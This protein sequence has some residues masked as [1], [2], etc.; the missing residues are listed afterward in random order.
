MYC[1]ISRSVSEKT[2]VR[3]PN[4]SSVRYVFCLQ[5]PRTA[6]KGTENGDNPESINL[7]ALEDFM[8]TM[9]VQEL[10]LTVS[11][12]VEVTCHRSLGVLVL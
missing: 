2:L 1:H 8:K 3:S 6:A 5:M 10:C 4:I 11:G 7:A 12:T 9:Q